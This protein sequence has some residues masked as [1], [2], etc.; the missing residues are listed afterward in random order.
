MSVKRSSGGPAS[1]MY[2]DKKT[3]M[4][5]VR[6]MSTQDFLESSAAG[7]AERR[8]AH[9]I[10]V[11]RGVRESAIASV[12]KATEAMKAGQSFL[13]YPEGTRSPDGRLQE[14]KKGA[15]V[16]AIK[17]GVPIVP[18]A[19]SGA[20]R[21]MEKRSLVIHPGEIVVEFLPPIDASKYSLEERDVLNQTVHDV[22]AAALPPDQRP[23]R[24]PGAV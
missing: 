17:A 6:S 21:V 12:E 3:V 4:N 8:S 15:V 11:N 16:M 22:M 1:R 18:V 23:I 20:Q 7:Q 24:F 10:P 13:I 9:F 5:S 14:F 2:S 19:C